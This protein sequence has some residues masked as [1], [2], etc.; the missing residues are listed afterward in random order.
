MSP[1]FSFILSEI[2][3][4]FENPLGGSTPYL[5]VMVCVQRHLDG[6]EACSEV[7][8]GKCHESY[9]TSLGINCLKVPGHFLTYI[10]WKFKFYFSSHIVEP[11]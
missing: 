1:I 4:E 8:F 11:N 2:C 6:V 5:N 9:G 3:L 7:T 10:P